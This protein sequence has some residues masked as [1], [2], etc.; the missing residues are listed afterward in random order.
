MFNVLKDEIFSDLSKME[1]RLG[2]VKTFLNE[3]S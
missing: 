1:Q 3:M 2:R